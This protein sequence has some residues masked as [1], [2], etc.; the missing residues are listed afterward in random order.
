VKAEDTKRLKELERENQ[1]LKKLLAEQ[2]FDT[3]CSYV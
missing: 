2:A 3:R 1:R